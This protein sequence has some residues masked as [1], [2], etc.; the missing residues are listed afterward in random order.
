MTYSV[1]RTLI[2]ALLATT[3]TIPALAHDDA[4]ADGSKADNKHLLH[5]TP[6]PDGHVPS[7][8][9]YGFTV[10]GRDTLGGISDGLYTDVW[11]HKGFAYVGTFQEPTCDRSGVYISDIR[12]PSNPSMVGIIKS[13][14]DTRIND[15]KVLEIDGRDVLIHSLEPCGMLV[16]NGRAVGGGNGGHQ[17]GKVGISLWDVSDPSNPHALKQN[18]L[19]F[20]VHNTFPWTTASGETYLLIVDDIATDDL[21]IADISKPQSPKLITTTGIGT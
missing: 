15:V 17:L 21:K 18:F 1:Q 13:P 5:D 11:A 9:N 20:P 2:T 8:V 16:G 14:P 12:D 4:V 3:F 19:D 7:N 6:L 10:I